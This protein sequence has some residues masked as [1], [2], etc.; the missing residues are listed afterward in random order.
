[1]IVWNWI[2]KYILIKVN[3]LELT[4]EVKMNTQPSLKKSNPKKALSFIFNNNLV[5]LFYHEFQR[6]QS[7][8]DK[9]AKS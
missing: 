7:H 6:I 3:K 8:A 2:Q 5:N 9:Q 4:K 1:M